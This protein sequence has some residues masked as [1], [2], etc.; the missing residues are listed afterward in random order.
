MIRISWESKRR[1][2]RYPQVPSSERGV[3]HHPFPHTRWSL[4]SSPDEREALFFLG[5]MRRQEY[6]FQIF[7]ALSTKKWQELIIVLQK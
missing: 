4:F 7:T 6:G 3:P 2:P 1:L 5:S